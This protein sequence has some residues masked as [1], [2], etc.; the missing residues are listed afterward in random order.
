MRLLLLTSLVLMAV[1]LWAAPRNVILMI[2]DGMGPDI[3]TAAGAYQYGADYHAFGGAKLL[4]METLKNYYYAMTFSLSGTGYD[5]TWN[6][7]DKEYPKNNTTDSAAAGTALA[8][9]VKTYNG[10]IAVDL[11]K[12]PLVAIT[13]LARQAGLK[14][15]VITSVPFYDATPACFAAHNE[16]RGNATAISHEMLMVTQ[17]DVLMGGG[18]PDSAAADQTYTNISKED[19]TAIK[20]GKTPYQLVQERADFQ[21]LIAKP[22]TGKVLGLFRNSYALTARNADGKS[23]DAKLPTLAEMTLVSLGALDNPKGFFLMVEGG[24]IDK[25]AHPNNLD[26]T[27]G[28]TLAFDEA[29]AVTINWITNHG[30]WEQN[31]LIITAD[32]DTGYLNNVKPVA[33]GKLPTV[34]WGTNG[35]WGNHTNRPVPVYCQ[36][37][38][39]ERFANYGLH[40][41]DFE[42]G[43]I[44]VVNN[45]D[46]FQVMKNA[47][48]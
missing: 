42:R 43:L 5:F 1:V 34:S 29:I 14:I 30:G 31:L 38:G 40:T 41:Q 33:A 11:H 2:G 44:N 17:P 7:G 46:I 9:G 6:N 35:S 4:T 8:T 45:T 3:V 23:A 18:D 25:N 24:A 36:G 26:A 13:A 20:T 47:L 19:W 16:G 21:A 32:H 48:Q 22:A 37:S 12:Q 28:E 27:V 15:G 39:S 10:A